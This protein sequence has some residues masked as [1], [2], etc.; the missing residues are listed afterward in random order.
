M[1]NSKKTKLTEKQVT[2]VLE[3]LDY[4]LDI[5]DA[6]MLNGTFDVAAFSKGMT[7]AGAFTP[8]TQNEIMKRLNIA[9]NK[10]PNGEDIEKA[11][12]SPI[13]NEGNIV[14]Y[15]QSYYFSSLMYKRNQEYS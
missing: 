12:S 6:Q 1:S 5:R 15:G 14:N 8:Y 2:E 13:E 9:T 3:A 7:E 11:L 10:T 4:A